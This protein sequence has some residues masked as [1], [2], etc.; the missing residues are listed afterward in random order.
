M[1]QELELI[2][3]H[4]A[5]VATLFGNDAAGEVDAEELEGVDPS[6]ERIRIPSGGATAFEVPG[7]DPDNP[8]IVKELQCVIFHHHRASVLWL[9]PMSDRGGADE[10]SRP[11]AY[12][13]DG[14]NQVVSEA[15]YAYCEQH[16]LP[17]PGTRLAPRGV[18][19]G[20]PDNCP[21]SIWGS[22]QLIDPN[23]SAKGK[24]NKDLRRLYI[25]RV[26]SPVPEI[27]TLSPTSLKTFDRWLTRVRS[28]KNV[29]ASITLQKVQKGSLAWSVAQFKTVGTLDQETREQAKQAA[30]MLKAMLGQQDAAPALSGADYPLEAAKGSV[31]ASFVDDTA[32]QATSADESPA[33]QTLGEHFGAT[34]V[35]DDGVF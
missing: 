11:H 16:G 26:G 22:A 29:L 20:H 3:A 31:V 33:V 34:E 17:R 14:I 25:A 5:R 13:N 18:D 12:S 8:D 30:L 7:D 4:D 28:T 23:A 35:I 15:G 21:Y 10:D 1:K 9:S 24:A 6:F 27:L 19:D 2:P 32:P